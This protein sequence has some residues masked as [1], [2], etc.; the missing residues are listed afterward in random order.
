MIGLLVT[1]LVAAFAY[2]LLAGITGSAIL[3]IVAAILV[4]LV[5]FGYPGTHYNRRP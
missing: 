4:L 3:G 1:L 2:L 5:G